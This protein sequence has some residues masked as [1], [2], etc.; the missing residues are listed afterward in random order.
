[1]KRRE[2]QEYKNELEGY[3]YLGNSASAMD[4]TGLIPSAPRSEAEWESYEAVYHY[5]PRVV[6]KREKPTGADA[7]PEKEKPKKGE[8]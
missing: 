5:R 7:G 4:C 6:E 8:A 2:E 1:M 3:D